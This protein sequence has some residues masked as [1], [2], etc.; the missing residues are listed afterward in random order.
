MAGTPPWKFFAPNGRRPSS[1]SLEDV[2]L[3]ATEGPSG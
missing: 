2:T 1:D 3:T